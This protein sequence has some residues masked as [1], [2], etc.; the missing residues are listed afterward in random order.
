MK[1]KG[2]SINIGLKDPPSYWINNNSGNLTLF[3]C[4]N[5]ADF[6]YE[7]FE[8]FGFQKRTILKGLGDGLTAA[9]FTNVE[10]AIKS[11]QTELDSDGILVITYSGHG[12]QSATLAGNE[13]DGKNEYWVLDGKEMFDDDLIKLLLPFKSTQRILIISDSCHSGTMID[14]YRILLRNCFKEITSSQATE[15]NPVFD[16]DNSVNAFLNSVGCKKVKFN[17]KNWTKQK[18]YLDKN[19]KNWE[20]LLPRLKTPPKELIEMYEVK[21]NKESA[22]GNPTE[23]KIPNLKSQINASVLLMAACQ[24]KQSAADNFRGY[25]NKFHGLYTKCLID[26]LFE[27]K[28]ILTNGGSQ[29]VVNGEREKLDY[30]QLNEAIYNR[31]EE[32]W[33]RSV[34]WRLKQNPH[35]LPIGYPNSS[36]PKQGCF[37]I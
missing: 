24:E 33:N 8:K 20:N 37:T 21:V 6:M 28:Q 1:Y 2:I 23:N 5:D 30:L 11:A 4:E 27:K 15:V 35:I 34:D 3:G 17:K 13:L 10:N 14:A 25:N 31:I 26:I 16:I 7:L 18:K 22:N 36:F 32:I 9:H 12:S 19:H 29:L